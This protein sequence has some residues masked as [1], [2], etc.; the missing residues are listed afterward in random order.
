MDWR[1]A[2]GSKLVSPQEAVAVVSSGMMVGCSL[3]EPSDL[4]AALAQR[5]DVRDVTVVSAV[6]LPGGGSL[7]ASGRF[8]VITGFATPV[9]YP[10]LRQ[11]LVEYIPL[12]FSQAHRLFQVEYQPDVVMVRLK[13][14]RAHV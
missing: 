13:I 12:Q 5:E 8:R 3:T 4:C 6:L 10:L 11:G 7:A 9:S 2:F 1:A 14:G